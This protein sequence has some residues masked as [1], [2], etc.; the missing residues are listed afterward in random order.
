VLARA[1]DP[2]AAEW[3]ARAH[4]ALQAH[5]A[6]LLEPALRYGFLNNIPHHREIVAAWAKRMDAQSSQ[7][8]S[9]VENQIPGSRN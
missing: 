2:R 6:N 4:N 3:L 9:E 1:H 7:A 8:A 5:A